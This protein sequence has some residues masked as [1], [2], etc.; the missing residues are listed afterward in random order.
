MNAGEVA[1]LCR[2]AR[3]RCQLRVPFLARSL[4]LSD[5]VVVERVQR[6]DMDMQRRGGSCG[7]NNQ[8]RIIHV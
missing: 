6:I 3:Y 1:S 4:P 5:Q 8:S 7:W 2:P